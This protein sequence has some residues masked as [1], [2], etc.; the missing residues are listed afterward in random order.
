MLDHMDFAVNDCAATNH[1]VPDSYEYARKRYSDYIT[2]AAGKRRIKYGFGWAAGEVA[3]DTYA[4]L[5]A[6]FQGCMNTL[7][8]FRVWSGASDC[9]IF[10]S[11]QINHAFRFVHD[12]DHV[13]LQADLS[14]DGEVKVI[15][16]FIMEVFHAAGFVAAVLCACDLLGQLWYGTN[17]HG[18][19]VDN[20]EA[21]VKQ[22][23]S[24]LIHHH[25]AQNG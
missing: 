10:T 22:L 19:F 2:F 9:T 8:P 24:Y 20:Q 5:I 4:K 3:P 25:G 18:A 16:P 13:I 11:P 12:T 7:K 21:F 17:N 14:H 6:E 23:Y 1:A 15:I